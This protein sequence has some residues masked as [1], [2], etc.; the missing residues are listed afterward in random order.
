MTEANRTDVFGMPEQIRGLAPARSK[1]YPP[2]SRVGQI[3]RARVVERLRM[4]A[5]DVLL[6]TAPAGYGKSTMLAEVAEGDGRATAWLTIDD[7]DND[8]TV[9]LAG[10]A[11]ALETIEPIDWDLFAQ[12]LHSPISISSGA[13]RGFGWMLAERRTPFL[14][15]IDDVHELV[16]RE[17]VDVLDAL[18][19]ALP[20]GSAI[21][22]SGRDGSRLHQG[23][24]RRSRNIE[25]VGLDELAFGTE[26]TA[27][28]CSAL[29]IHLEPQEIGRVMERTEGWPLAVYLAAVARNHTS[30]ADSDAVPI[31]GT[32]RVL[33]EFFSD[34]LLAGLE[35][36]TAEFLMALSTLERGS[37]QMCDE[38]FRRTGSAALLEDLERRNLLVI[39]LDDRREW[40][41]LHHLWA[42]FLSTELDRRDPGA[43]LRLAARASI[44]HEAH[45]G[46]NDAIMNAAKAGDLDRVEQLVLANFPLFAAGGRLGT[47][48]RWLALFERADL[49]ARPHLLVVAGFLKFA[50]GD[51]SAALEWLALSNERAELDHAEA[52]SGWTSAVAGAALR[53][54][55]GCGSAEEMAADA[56]FVYDHLPRGVDWQ[57]FAC[58][59]YGAAAFMLGDHAR[60]EQLLR[61]GAF[62]AA[63]R[64]LVRALNLSQLA[65][66]HIERDEWDRAAELGDDARS[67]V[68][69][70]DA[71]PMM[72]LV[73][74]VAAAIESRRGDADGAAERRMIARQQLAGFE[75][76]APWLNL[77][78][79]IALARSSLNAGN[80]VEASTLLDEAY[81]IL[82]MVPDAATARDQVANL[83]RSATT[84]SRSGSFG[85]SSLTTAELRVLQFLPTHLSIGEIAERLF[86]SRNTVKAQ[87]IA[88]YRKLGT[89]SRGGAVDIARDA[90]LID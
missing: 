34:V 50:Y 49:L 90:G 11:V 24:L 53:A 63:E 78:T 54:A 23:S 46:V 61:E 58:L 52:E 36:A 84:R 85:P 80:R 22:L 43:S 55:V 65:I 59:L 87:S 83:R 10:V 33:A 75:G 12:L 68:R 37:G 40:Y 2:R 44:W 19:A 42:E 21:A 60:A 20:E 57:P 48:D 81:E 41:R 45:G 82:E 38:V 17:A 67:T 8:P 28:V 18:I 13:L 77:Q 30:R 1:L 9:L 86:V 7:A 6:V 15:I 27:Q 88:I 56:R 76:I 73:S 39:S 5:W 79:R 3:S 35:P 25:E 62:G 32:T 74:A 16:A 89:S 70:L 64:P 72:C 69:D 71:T 29:G 26:D 66:V 47:V 31:G 51:G 4:M 14:L